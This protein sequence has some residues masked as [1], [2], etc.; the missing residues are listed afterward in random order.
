M[1]KVIVEFGCM[2]LNPV[3][4][5]FLFTALILM[6]ISFS[7]AQH[8]SQTAAKRSSCNLQL[9]MK[10]AKK[11]ENKILNQKEYMSLTKWIEALQ[12]D[13]ELPCI[14]VQE[15]PK[16]V[17]MIFILSGCDYVSYFVNHG[18]VS[19]HKYCFKYS[20]YNYSCKRENGTT[21]PER[22]LSYPDPTICTQ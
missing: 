19:F 20:K 18:K 14:P 5:G 10:N 9:C 6:F 17:C 7:L 15:H 2:F 8:R 4:V 13:N 12:N 11:Q 21:I 1:K 16:F 3:L 22:L